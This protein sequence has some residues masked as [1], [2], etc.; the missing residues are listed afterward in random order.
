[1]KKDEQAKDTP[2]VNKTTPQNGATPADQSSS[3]TE[4]AKEKCKECN[5][6]AGGQNC[7][8]E[9]IENTEQ[10]AE[11]AG[12]FTEL[13]DQLSEMKNTYLRL[14]AEYDNYRKRTSKE[15]EKYY[16]LAKAETIERILP[17]YDNIERAV[18]NP[19]TDEAYKKGVEM[20]FQQL[21]DVFKALGVTEIEAENAKFDPEKHNAVMHIEDDQFGENSIVE[22]FQRGFEIDGYVIRHA[23]VKVAN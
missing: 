20:I 8:T 16:T 10:K 14:L 23:V 4:S 9:P 15:K 22:V 6:G 17:V 12:S 19:T 3:D 13:E 7:E 18:N 2:E 5:C 21:Q 1:V 11:E